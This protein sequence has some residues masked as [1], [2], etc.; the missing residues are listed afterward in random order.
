MR[1]AVARIVGGALLLLAGLVVPT[2][3]AE[4][5]VTVVGDFEDDSIAFS[6]GDV[7]GVLAADCVARRESIPARG[8]QCLAI[9][10]GATRATVSAAVDLVFR[11][12]VRFD[13]VDHIAGFCWIKKAAARVS[14][15][16]RDAAGQLFETPHRAITQKHRWV[17]LS[18]PIKPDELKRIRGKKGLEWPVQI[19]GCRLETT[20][21]GSQTIYL[22]DLQVEHRVAQNQTLR[23]SFSFDQPTKL[24]DPGAT[25]RAAATLENRSR[26][27]A[28]AVT[29]ELAWTRTDG[30]VIATQ[31]KAVNL[32]ASGSD[33]RSY[34]SLDFSL[35]I[36]EP[37]LY[38]LVAK[39]LATGWTKPQEFS[40]TI[41]VTPSNRGLPSGRQVLFAVRS[42]LLR[43]PVTDQILEIDVA[44]DIGVQLLVLETPWRLI[45]AKENEFDFS[46]LEKPIAALNEY[47]IAPMLAISGVP[48]WLSEDATDRRARVEALVRALV[49]H[50]SARVRYLALPDAL[51]DDYEPLATLA[52]KLQEELGQTVPDLRVLPPAIDAEQLR[53]NPDWVASAKSDRNRNLLVRTRGASTEA[54]KHLR[55][56][57]GDRPATWSDACWWEHVSEPLRTAGNTGTAEALLEHYLAAARAGVNALVYVDL[58]DDDNN[59][60]NQDALRGFVGRDFSPKASLLGFASTLGMLYNTRYAGSVRGLPTSYDSAL[61]VGADRQVAVLRPRPNRIQ[62]A[63]LMP[64]Q[65][66]EGPLRANDFGRRPIEMQSM[67][68]SRLLFPDRQPLFLTLWMSTPQPEPQI[69]FARPWITV[70]ETV[71][72]EAEPFEVAVRVPKRQT[73]YVQVVT[74]RDAPYSSAVSTRTLRSDGNWSR[75][76]IDLNAQ[77]GRR[78]ERSS[79]TLRVVVGNERTEIPINVVP[80]ATAPRLQNQSARGSALGELL[81]SENI[82][83]SATVRA[84]GGYDQTHVRLAIEIE[85]DRFVPF[86]RLA[87]GSPTGDVLAVG[88]AWEG[89]SGCELNVALDGTIELVGGKT[90]GAARAEVAAPEDNRRIIQLTIKKPEKTPEDRMIRLALRYSDDDADGYPPIELYWGSGLDGSGSG[91]A[92]RW[93]RPAE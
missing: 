35:Q 64:I 36:D 91:R 9:D 79:L 6:V 84:S 17:A 59:P 12:P 82:R 41:A 73:S 71:F 1:N 47:E 43:E 29:V 86:K 63:V 81:P 61:F 24:Y 78:F 69:A 76:P 2:Q 34:Q 80:L 7:E 75:V 74:P 40:T 21:M 68:G 15:R 89:A 58:R 51:A 93:V 45:E 56:A 50:F 62:P 20:E 26:K 42:N 11:E 55:A 54:L 52:A 30:T 39:A 23:G 85:D 49:E 72:A 92:Y 70:P 10:I 14:F 67:H 48:V 13:Q 33:F 65:G 19:V 16:L 53:A 44:R 28:L 90:T 87:N 8:Q 83:A 4:S 60:R 18:I 38:R 88:F 46:A 5:V 25:V 66:V 77:A 27:R 3:A 22:D 32:P 37:G 31:R 57:F